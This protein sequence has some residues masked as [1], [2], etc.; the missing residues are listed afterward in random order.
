MVNWEDPGLVASLEFAFKQMNVFCMGLAIWEFVLTFWFDW[1]I[2]TRRIP[3]RW[4]YLFWFAGRASIFTAIL[5]LIIVTHAKI[6][7]NC[8][9]LIPIMSA[10]GLIGSACA[11][12]LLMIR[13]LAIWQHNMIVTWSLRLM[14]LAQFTLVIYSGVSGLSSHWVPEINACTIESHNDAILAANFVYTAVFDFIIFSFCVY[15]VSRLAARTKLLWTLY[16][17]GL[18]YVVFTCVVNIPAAVFTILHLNAVMGVLFPPAAAV[19]SVIL[20]CRA[21]LSLQKMAPDSPKSSLSEVLTRSVTRRSLNSN[22]EV[23]LEDPPTSKSK[24]EK[25]IPKHYHNQQLTT[26]FDFPTEVYGPDDV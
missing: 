3:F 1:A 15:G 25:R 13:T 10:A 5:T 11:S 18:L 26:Q 22:I 23:T 19:F 6:K 4:A 24:K 9:A 20:S 17:Q 8:T 21:L 12:T 14:S 16:T 2:F 7:L